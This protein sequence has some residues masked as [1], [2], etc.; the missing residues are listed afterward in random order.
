MIQTTSPPTMPAVRADVTAFAVEQGVTE[1]L[2]AVLAMTE[3]VFAPCGLT[4]TLADDP[5]IPS[6]RHIVFEVDVTPLD[7][8]QLF[9]AQTRWS[10]ELFQHCPATHGHVFRYGLVTTV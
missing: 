1:Y 10:R 4:V 5:E 7:E 9:A 6:D 8:Q 2:P 3:R